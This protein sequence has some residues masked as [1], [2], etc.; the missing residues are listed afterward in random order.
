MRNTKVG[1]NTAVRQSVL[2][3]AAIGEDTRIGP[4][5]YLR[6]GAVVGDRCRIGS[7]VEIKKSNIGN[8][9]NMAH[10]AYIGDADVGN[11]VNYGCGAITAN[12]DGKKKYRTVIA[13]GAF[14]GCNTNLIAPVEIGEGALIAAGSTID[15]SVPEYSLGIAR[16]RQITKENWVNRKKEQ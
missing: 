10:L 2:T 13:D 16:K 4:F 5:A 14:I 12:Y 11:K 3:D 6:D 8:E 15:Q 9:T 1:K 7:F